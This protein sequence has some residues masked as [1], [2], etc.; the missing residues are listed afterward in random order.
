MSAAPS[1]L[2][3]V[4]GQALQPFGVRGPMGGAVGG[5]APV[6]VKVYALGSGVALAGDRS[7]LA[8][9]EGAFE[10]EAHGK[11]FVIDPLFAARAEAH[12]F[13]PAVQGHVGAIGHAVEAVDE[14]D[15]A[16][17]GHIDAAHDGG[18]LLIETAILSLPQGMGKSTIAT[19]LAARIG[20]RMVIDE[21]V[22]TQGLTLGALHLTS[23]EIVQG[24]A[25]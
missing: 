20:C 24:G 12:R 19:H 9:R 16:K 1:M 13:V 15:L 21:W 14:K 18:S 4:P 17:F 8:C 6:V 22:P 23:C 3:L 25:A 11:V 5:D 7:D 10:L 2:N